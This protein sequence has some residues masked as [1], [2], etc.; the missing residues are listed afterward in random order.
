MK[1]N[2]DHSIWAGDDFDLR[3]Q[4]QYLLTIF[5]VTLC[6]ISLFVTLIQFVR[7]VVLPGRIQKVQEVLVDVQDHNTHD[8]LQQDED[9]ENLLLQKTTTGASV[10]DVDRPRGAVARVAVELLLV[11]CQVGLSLTAIHYAVYPHSKDRRIRCQYKPRPLTPA[12]AGSAVWLY[13]LVLVFARLILTIRDQQT[14][15]VRLWYHTAFLYGAQWF[16][17]IWV[18]RSWTIHPIPGPAGRSFHLIVPQFTL[19]TFLFL[20]AMA[21]RKGNGAILIEHEDSLEPSHEPTASVLSLATFSWVDPIVW[22]GWKRTLELSD[23]WNVALKDK[24]DAVLNDFRQIKKTTA[25]TYRLLRYFGWSLLIQ[26]AWAMFGSVFT[27]LPTLLL[28]A[29]LQY[30]EDPSGQSDNAAWLYVVLLFVTGAIEGMSAGQALWIG[31]KVCIRLRAIIV[32][33]LYSKTLRRKA[34][35]SKTKELGTV[36]DPKTKSKTFRERLFSIFIKRDKAQTPSQEPSDAQVDNGTIINLMSVDSFRVAD[37]A[38]YLHFLWGS[39]PVQLIMSV[40]LLY[41]FLGPA[42]LVGIGV[43]VLLVPVNLFIAKRFT[44]AQKRIMAATDRRIH[45][46]N[47]V[48]QNIRIIKYFAWEQRFM[49]NVNEKRK[50]ELQALWKRYILWAGAYTVWTGVPVLITFLSFFIYTVVQ[51]RPLLPSVAF[52]ALSMFSLLRLPLD[53]LADMVAHVQEAKVSVDRVEEFLNEEETQKYLQLEQSRQNGLEERQIGLDKATL[54]WGPTTRTEYVQTSDAFSLIDIDVDFAIGSLNV[55]AGP[56][57][58]GKTSLLMALLGEMKLVSG[59]VHLPGGFVRQRLVPDRVTG[60]TE[61]VAYCAQQAWLVNDTIKENILFAS[62]YDA[63]RYQ[64]VLSVCALEKDLEI[65]ASGDQT[66]VGEKGISLSGGQKQRISLARAMY[67]NSKHLLLDDCLSAVD[68]H[69]AKHIFHQAIIGP[70]MN[71]RTCILVT[72]NVGLV[73]PSA[74]YIVVLD[75]GKVAAQGEANNVIAS[76]MLGPDIMKSRPQSRSAS[77]AP[78]PDSPNRR[79]EES[80]VPKNV[81]RQSFANGQTSEL[82]VMDQAADLRIEKKAEGSVRL[83]IIKLYLAAM[84]PWY[85]WIIAALGFVATQVGNVATNLWIRQ[86]ANAYHTSTSS[87][88]HTL[89]HSFRHQGPGH[90]SLSGGISLPFVLETSHQVFN[91]SSSSDHYDVD[92]SYYLGVYALIGLTYVFICFSREFVL[93]WG[94]ITASSA[95]HERLLGSIL[96]AKFRFFD[97]TPLGQLV[98]RFSKDIQS[99]DQDVSPV[100]IGM[101]H[102]GASV[103]TIVILIS[104]ITPGF[105]IPGAF[106]ACIYAATGMFYIRS[107]RDLKRIEAVQRSPLFQHFGETLSGVVTIRAYG[108][109]SRFVAD[110]HKYVNAHN[111]PFLYLWAANRW[112]AFRIDFAGAL[113]SFSS[114]LFVVL[115]AKTIDAGAAGLALTYAITFTQNVLWLVRLYAS[116]EQNMNSV[117]RVQEYIDVEQEAK[118]RIPE[119]KPAANWPSR[120]IVEFIDYSTRYR[121]D[122]GL[123]LDGL[124][125]KID[126]GA[127]VGI[128]GRTGAG[129]SSLALALFRGLEA[130]KGKILIDDVDIGLIGL[131]DLR[132]AITIVPQDPTL[133]TGTI[134]NNLDPFDLFTD[135]DIFAALQKVQLIHSIPLEAESSGIATPDMSGTTVTSSPAST[136]IHHGPSDL[137]HPSDPRLHPSSPTNNTTTPHVNK[138][139]FRTLSSPVAES[140]SNLSQGQRQLLCLA[141]ALLKSPKVLIMDE[142][143][144]SIDYA[145]DAKIQ[146]VLRELKGNTIITIA[147]RLQTIIDYDKVLVLDR[148][149]VVEYGSPWEL[150]QTN[151]TG[152]GAGATVGTD[153]ATADETGPGQFRAMCMNSGDFEGLLEGARKADKARK[154]VDISE[155]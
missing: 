75:N 103:I 88:P 99:I 28:R 48:L 97:T 131:Q 18:L 86:W 29:I 60:L 33:E 132:E 80:S 107:S 100:A 47:E 74:K 57:G 145:T 155:N 129:K 45:A 114:G 39:T 21:L 32:G 82:N 35:A 3:F 124:T 119:T 31:R 13:V 20:Q 24:A 15:I 49:N 128:V 149:K 153:G 141:R 83:A 102:S 2:C 50:A 125:L 26:A 58:S 130:E 105:L 85:F 12:I 61:S 51:N 71:N 67:C 154:L 42:S 89:I 135:E 139:I 65:F 144:A 1:H 10:I 63:E 104:V 46:T 41:R 56:T 59:T 120:G 126:A 40:S 22:R 136:V 11:L 64:S 78:S 152:A 91:S 117:E 134:R 95:L 147:H 110:S 121:D 112:L 43:M 5:P 6:A 4:H 17:Q 52:P 76:G 55:I 109:E 108:D 123:V 148:G 68:S 96:R 9:E 8:Q 142:A 113:V 115:N 101:I 122:L 94:A 73:V 62:P 30:L 116:N 81:R 34:A 7:W 151:G 23:V 19:S 140:G 87:K 66:L 150:L 53:A 16:L 146:D 138:N 127:K 118:A 54:S 93:F 36:D 133:F 111:R 137:K 37:V 38:A 77:R 27:F 44:T 79:K 72:H 25:L 84:G 92:T 14:R 106:I 143:T 69:T 98:N 90:S 70:L